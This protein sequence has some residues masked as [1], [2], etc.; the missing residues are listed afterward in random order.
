MI[1]QSI[2]TRL[3]LGPVAL[4]GQPWSPGMGN[5]SFSTK[6]SKETLELEQRTCE[7]TEHVAVR[8]HPLPFIHKARVSQQC[9][10]H[11]DPAGGAGALTYSWALLQSP[12]NPHVWVPAAGISDLEHSDQSPQILCS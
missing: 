6:D 7:Q 2:G 8:H 1:P 12:G 4:E 5:D 9:L 10:G 3:W 11:C